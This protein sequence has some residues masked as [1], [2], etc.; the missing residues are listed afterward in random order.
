MSFSPS[1]S[2]F[3]EMNHFKEAE[4]VFRELLRR[5]PE[6]TTYYQELEKSLQLGEQC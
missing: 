5:N 1:G 2:L 4:K 6:N 3:L